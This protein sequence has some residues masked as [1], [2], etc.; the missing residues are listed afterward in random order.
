MPSPSITERRCACTSPVPSAPGVVPVMKPTLPGHTLLPNGRAPQCTALLSAAGIER[1]CSGVTIK[2]PSALLISSLKRA[3]SGPGLASLSWLYI[4][5]SSMHTKWASNLSAPS[6][7]SAW[8]YLGLID[9]LRC[10]PTMTA[11]VG[12][13]MVENLGYDT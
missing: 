4:G 1:L 6:L 2:T 7:A 12:L 11:T 8:A 9:S 5:R 13:G 3:T 10:E